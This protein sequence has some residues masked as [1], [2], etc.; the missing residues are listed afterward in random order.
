MGGIVLGTGMLAALAMFFAISKVFENNIIAGIIGLFWGLIIFNLDRFIV[1]STGKGDGKDTISFSEL[2]HAAPRLAMAIVIGITI[3]APLEIKIFEKEIKQQWQEMAR[4]DLVTYKNE[5]LANHKKSEFDNAT[6]TIEE[7]K[8]EIDNQ[9]T[10][11]IQI[12]NERIRF[13]NNNGGCGSKCQK[14]EKL[15]AAIRVEE[16]TKRESIAALEL[17][18]SGINDERIELENEYMDT[19]D[20]DKI[21]ILNSLTALDQYPG[22]KWPK[23]ML[24]LL[25]VFV[26][27]APVFFKLMLTYGPYDLLKENTMRIVLAKE[28]VE[29][30]ENYHQALRDGKDHWDEITFHQHDKVV[31]AEIELNEKVKELKLL[32]IEKWYEQE[33]AKVEANPRNYISSEIE[34]KP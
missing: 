23:R 14:Y 30:K 26:E 20:V 29:I 22:S 16:S 24:M 17:I 11:E 13:E 33:K 28:G 10:P 6:A 1:S 19:R 31:A 27:V 8:S 3:A 34:P 5:K 21:G 25:L 18:V 9:L 15:L 12:L 7:L 4:A 2:I 32:A